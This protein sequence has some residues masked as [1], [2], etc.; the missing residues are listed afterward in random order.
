M[1]ILNER[2]YAHDVFCGTNTEVKA[3]FEKIKYVTRFQLYELHYN[4]EDNYNYTVKWLNEHHENFNENCYSQ[5]IADSVRMASKTPFFNIDEIKITQNELDIISSLDNVRTEKILF[6]LLCMAKQQQRSCGFMNGLVKYS[7]PEL[8]K[9][10]RV[11]VPAEEREYLLHEIVQCGYL[12]CPHKV[13]TQCLIV[14]FIDSDGEAVLK[15]NEI[16][17]K[18]LAYVY[19]QWKNGGG[20]DRCQKCGR[21]YRKNKNRRFCVEC[22]KYQKVGDKIIECVDCGKMVS[23]DARN[24]KKERCDSCQAVRNILLKAERNKRY[25]GSHRNSDGMFLN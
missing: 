16:D 12:S 8:C 14:N 23:V 6:V 11:S 25:Y 1:L 15:I 17:A 20:Y 9:M 24:N 4:D 7:L 10:A 2:Q 18:E 3:I 22:G 5:L 21:L 13:D 19:L